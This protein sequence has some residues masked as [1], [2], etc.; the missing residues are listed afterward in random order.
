VT[1][2]AAPVAALAPLLISDG[3]HHARRPDGRELLLPAG[4]LLLILN[5]AEAEAHAR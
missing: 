4:C 1:T 5:M 3:H 2:A